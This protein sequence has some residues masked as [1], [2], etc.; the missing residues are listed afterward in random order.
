MNKQPF[1]SFILLGSMRSGSNLLEKFL[2]QYDRLVCYGELF[3][4]SFIGTQGCQKFLSID[5]KTRNENPH[6]LLDKIRASNDQKITGFRF[7]QDH[8]QKVLDAALK[9]RFCAKIILTR[10]PLESFVSLQI[11]LKTNQWLVSDV[12]HRK[13]A[14]IHFDLKEYA[15]YLKKR[16]AFYDKIVQT[17]ELSE[18]P[19]FEI[20]YEM[21]SALENI[22]SL[23]A[24]I[25]DRNGKKWL[26]EPIK[27]QNP[28][29]VASKI[30]NIAEV[31][32]AIDEPRLLEVHPP[33]LKPVL[34]KDT[35]CSRV[36]FC[37][38]TPLAF[39]PQ[40]AVPDSGV[41]KWLEFQD[42]RAPQ[43]GY[44]PH[45]FAEWQARNL[46]SHF[47][48]VVCHPVKRTYNAFMEKIFST[49]SG[50]YIS[51]RQELENQFGMIL[52]QGN[53]APEQSKFTLEQN[54]YGLEEH[55]ISFKLFLIFVAANLGNETKIRQDGKWQLQTEI[56]RRYWIMHPDV[57]V[58]KEENLALGLKYLE[59]RL[60]LSINPLWKNESGTAFSFP[61]TQVYDAEIEALAR[62][63]Y[64]QDYDDF[65]YENWA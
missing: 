28:G 18:Q 36:Y 47:F 21:L 5:L 9:D 40:P 1:T 50:S 6:L 42:K 24:F 23:A 11:A 62:A 58:L 55:R 43:N 33:K 16:S 44:S 61:L 54:G 41:R 64:G 2:N 60:N 19:Y 65:S 4:K 29:A 12:A 26:A 8:D 39:G 45:E 31:R 46:S 63:A 53:I 15:R 52:P 20:D 56:I 22:N 17:L 3:H 7:F 35:D 49:T 14:Q 25:G 32:A 34:E 57:I 48:T 51:I 10:D 37:Q 59:N 38:N 30:S 27:R 13:E